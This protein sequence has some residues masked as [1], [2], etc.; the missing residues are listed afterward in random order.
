[1]L[2]LQNLWQFGEILGF[3]WMIFLTVQFTV[4]V[5]V[6]G[7]VEDGGSGI[8]PVDW[9]TWTEEI[10]SRIF[11]LLRHLSADS[12]MGGASRSAIRKELTKTS[13]LPNICAFLLF[14]KL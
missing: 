2:L 3:L 11:A 5:G 9:S 14:S 1:M 4:Q 8:L 10:L 7:E 13:F 12:A 6:I